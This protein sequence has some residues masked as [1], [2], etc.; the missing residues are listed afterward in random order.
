MVSPANG[1]DPSK[2]YFEGIN[3]KFQKELLELHI[4]DTICYQLDHRP[5]N[6]FVSQSTNKD[7]F[8]VSAFDNDCTT[9]FKAKKT[10]EENDYMGC[11]ALFKDGRISVPFLPQDIVESIKKLDLSGIQLEQYLSKNKLKLWK[12]D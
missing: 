1:V 5:G 10:I 12:L 7:A 8:G 4:L 3:P 6:Y 9:G 11:S 2:S